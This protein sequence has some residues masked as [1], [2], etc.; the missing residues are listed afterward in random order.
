[1]TKKNFFFN[2]LNFSHTHNQLAFHF[3]KNEGQNLTRFH[4]SIVPNE[5]INHFEE[6]KFYYTSFDKEIDN[7]LVISKN[8]SPVFRPSKEDSTQTEI[9]PNSCFS[10][11]ILKEYYYS[12]LEEYFKSHG[13]LIYPN[14]IN[15]MDIWVP[16]DI[17]DSRF[18]FYNRFT[19]RI[20]IASVTNKPELLL[21]YHGQSRV[22]KETMSSLYDKIAPELF[23][24][25]IYNNKIYKRKDLP[26]EAKQGYTEVYPVWNRDIHT[27][28]GLPNE[29]PVKS[30]RYKKY[31]THLTAFI[32]K[33]LTDENLKNII[34]I[35]STDFI[36]VDNLKIGEVNS[37]SNKL[38]FGGNNRNINPYLGIKENGPFSASPED[39][40]HLFFIYNEKQ[41][42][43]AKKFYSFLKGDEKGFKGFQKFTNTPFH[44]EKNFSIKFTNA[45]DPIP[46]INAQ[47][48]QK[49]FNPDSKYIAIYITPYSKDEAN[50]TE[51]K[52]YYLVKELLLHKNITSQVVQAHKVMNQE[53]YFFN[54]P[55]ISI[56]MLAKLNGQPWRLDST[57]KSELI[58]GVGAFRNPD[59][60]VKYI[61]SAFSFQNNGQFNNF[62]VFQKN[63]TTEL[64]GL[65][66]NSIRDYVSLNSKIKRLIIHFYKNMSQ[67]ELRPIEQ[68]LKNLG[69]DI[70][71]FII[72]INKTESNDIVAFDNDYINLMP[73]S[74]TYINIGWNKFLLF[75]NSRYSS[76]YKD[77]E[78]YPFPIKLS[79][80]CNKDHLSTDHKVIK[81]LIDQ[82][83]QF[84]RMYW[85]SISQQNLPVTIKYPAMLAEI[86]PH[87]SGH[88][89]PIFGKSNL[90]FL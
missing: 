32:N 83:Y 14:F 26:D 77:R 10:F 36:K 78:G 52:N 69:L 51:R 8:T 37:G 40:I 80:T 9:V 56:A 59:T 39:N 13:L 41:T 57:L 74:G 82:V 90:F 55:N 71:V 86:F 46:E 21:S 76:Y 7:A 29:A 1:M 3:V 61:G 16:L 43:A 6:Q 60:G 81:E 66:I 84:S 53:K 34:N 72:A 5:V 23:N 79:I 47:L 12:K 89:I 87:F 67:K 70:P 48:K 68:G 30:N 62:E 88:D 11:A 15:D 44:T 75:N 85:K 28:L 2:L 4:K 24:L 18:T 31:K 49:H 17:P 73:L 20:Q 33:Y 35:E 22:F 27:A 25:T 65:I 58:V 54:M 63:R 50:P 64:A 19:L 38:I 42:K 45:Q